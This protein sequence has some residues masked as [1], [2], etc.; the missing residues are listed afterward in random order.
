MPKKDR[1]GNVYTARLRANLKRSNVA[2]LLQKRCAEMATAA[3]FR[4]QEPGPLDYRVWWR[5]LPYDRVIMIARPAPL[6][7]RQD[8]SWIGHHGDPV[9]PYWSLTLAHNTPNVTPQSLLGV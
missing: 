7:N 9:S 2:R 4:N 1:F 5:E 3:G 8:E 6:G